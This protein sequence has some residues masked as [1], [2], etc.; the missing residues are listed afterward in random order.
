MNLRM[1]GM[2][3]GALAALAMSIGACG[4]SMG[5]AESVSS[6]SSAGASS[7]ATT[8]A[9]TTGAGGDGR[10]F[11]GSGGSDGAGNGGGDGAGGAAGAGNDG[12]T[13]DDGG[14]DAGAGSSSD[15]G[16]GGAGTGGADTGSGAGGS[17]AGDGG[18]GGCASAAD[19]PASLNE[20][21]TPTCNGGACGTSFVA[22]GTPVSAQ[23]AGDCKEAVC[24]G[25]GAT[26]AIAAAD[27]THDD[28]NPCTADGCNGGSVLHTPKAGACASPNNPAAKVCGTPGGDAEGTCVACNVNGD[29]MSGVCQAHVCAAPSCSDMVQNNGETDVDCGGPCGGCATAKKCAVAADCLDHVCDPALHTCSAPSCSDGKKNGAE[30]D[31][32]CGSACGFPLLCPDLS[33]CSYNQ[34]CASDVCMF[35]ICQV[36][37]CSDGMNNGGEADVDCGGPCAVK[38]ADGKGCQVNGDC[39]SG[40]C[41]GAPGNKTCQ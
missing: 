40:V 15:A 14:T 16:T 41:L 34:D 19:C 21:V 33:S 27:D 35:E 38:C 1:G 20:C 8:S 39:Q 18:I 29:C 28:Q 9:A 3:F 7:G 32:D 23:T 12:G 36:P 24:N 37:T 5:G 13:G 26:I 17:D 30:A 4:E 6:T 10:G 11:D 2:R 31:V 25:A 22:N